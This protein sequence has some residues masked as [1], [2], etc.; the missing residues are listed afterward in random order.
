KL[1][2][3]SE[4]GHLSEPGATEE[5]YKRIKGLRDGRRLGCQSQI[6]GD[7]VIDVPEESQI[8]RQ[9]VRKRA[10]EIRDLEI[11]PVV[12]LHYVELAK[13]SM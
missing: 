7:M 11:D 10:D 5:K 8:H 6:L 4:P 1:Q 3:V 13:P 9:V 2:I 12:T